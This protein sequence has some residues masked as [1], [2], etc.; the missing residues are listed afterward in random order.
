[1]KMVHTAVAVVGAL[2]LLALSVLQIRSSAEAGPGRRDFAT[3]AI[4]ALIVT[5]QYA[6]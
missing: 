2:I 3:V 6:F 4:I 1:M 5:L